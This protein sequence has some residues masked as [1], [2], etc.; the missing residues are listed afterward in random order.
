[1]MP[2]TLSA[3]RL[4]RAEYPPRLRPLGLGDLL[5]EVFGLY[6]RGFLPLVGIAALVGVPFVILTLWH[7]QL[8]ASG[9]RM[10]LPIA[11]LVL[12]VIALVVG[13]LQTAALCSATSMLVLGQA[14]RIGPA[15][16]RARDRIWPLVRLDLL[17]AVAFAVGAVVLTLV[18]GVLTSLGVLALVVLVPGVG[19]LLAPIIPVGMVAVVVALALVIWVLWTLAV[20]A[21]VLEEQ[22]GAIGAIRRSRA[23][24]R[25]ALGR[26][27]LT[28]LVLLALY[29]VLQVIA[30]ML[31]SLLTGQ[32]SVLWSAASTGGFPA[33]SAA[34]NPASQPVA[35]RV[36]QTLL[37]SVVNLVLT[38]LLGIGMTLIYYDRR[39]RVEAYDLSVQVSEL[40]Q[41]E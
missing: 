20:P 38:P 18:V 3:T 28:L 32:L 2:T 26:I 25:G 40:A 31:L 24:A 5:D 33:L 4:P 39:V 41:A 30:W 11:S 29:S 1:M 10:L 14:P 21:L 23:L 12:N 17:G 34:L 37:Y 27:L 35:V 13:S 22:L 19:W 9:D 16:R 6:R 7:Q 36:L 8:V 15:W